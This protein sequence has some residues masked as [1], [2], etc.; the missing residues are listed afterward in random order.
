MTLPAQIQKQQAQIQEL[1]QQ[2]AG[3]PTPDHVVDGKA[4]NPG[5]VAAP[6]SEPK[7]QAA[8][9]ETLLQ[10]YRTLQGMYNADIP[11]LRNELANKDQHIAELSDRLKQVEDLL[12][13]PQNQPQP[14]ALL[15]LITEE[16]KKEYGDAIEV[17]RKAAR[18]EAAAT[19]LPEIEKLKDIVANLQ[20]YV[21][22]IQQVEGSVQAAATQ[23]FWAD[24]TELVPSWQEI[25]SDEDF[26]TWLL[27]T[28]PMTGYQRQSFLAD[29][30][31]KLDARRVAAFFD[32]WA[33]ISGSG[34]QVPQPP[35]PSPQ[36]RQSGN[37]LEYQ[38]SP[39]RSRATTPAA[40]AKRTYTRAE[41]GQFYKD[42]TMGKYVGKEQEKLAL[43]ADIVLASREGRVTQ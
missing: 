23:R 16:D 35:N 26:R 40:P 1:Y 42:V 13:D 3:A 29:A 12:A 41:I 6:T 36:P 28:D 43:E 5:P 22:K 4:P 21:P 15:N 8:S 9:D 39:G 10:K 7:P 18:E 17:M 32:E 25:N 2:M 30:Q 19:Y 11:R 33:A 14:S 38:V 20:G 37:P 27:E 31:R 24:L 34:H